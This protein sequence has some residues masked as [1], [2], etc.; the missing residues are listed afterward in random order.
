MIAAP[1]ALVF[2]LSPPTHGAAKK[3]A[4]PEPPPAAVLDPAAWQVAEI[5]GNSHRVAESAGRPVMVSGARQVYLVTTAKHGPD[6]IVRASFRLTNSAARASFKI[7]AGLADPANLRESG[8]YASVGGYQGVVNWS[9]SDPGSKER[10]PVV[11]GVYRPQFAVQRSLGWPESL[12]RGV[13][14]DMVA[15]APVEERWLTFE[16]TLRRQGFEL[17][18]DGIPLTSVS[19]PEL[20]TGGFVRL[21]FSPH[22]ELARAE[23]RKV[24]A[25]DANWVYRPVP[26]AS[27]LN[28]AQI[29][30]RKL[31]RASLPRGT[32]GGVPFEFPEPDSRGNDHA[33][34][35]VSWFRQGNLDGRYSGRGADALAGRWTGAM[36]RDPARL[37][38]RLPM[39]RYR[40]LH[41]IAAADGEPDSVPVITAQF[42]R[43]QAG[44]PK[45]FAARVPAFSAR[46]DDA[47]AIPV[48][49]ADGKP[50]R[51]YH[52]TIPVDAGALAEFDDLDFVEVELTKEVRLYRASPDPM[53]YSTHAAG[54][55]SSVHVFALTAERPAVEMR[56]EAGAYGHIWTAPETPAYTVRLRN[57]QGPAREVRVE[58]TT[59]SFDGRGRTSQKKAVQ[60]PATGDQEVAVRFPLKLKAFGHHDVAVKIVDGGQTRVEPRGLAYLQPDTRERRDWDFGRG[61]LFGFWNW[62]GGHVTPSAEKQLLVMAKAGIES[63]PG[64]YED[65]VRRHGEET[66]K[67]MEQYGIFTLKFAGAG[68]HYITANF[69]K[70]LKSDG[71]EKARAEFI[72]KLKERQSLPGP[73]SRPTFISWYPE[74]SI[75]PLT[76]GIFP[77]YI[78][79]PPYEFTAY[80]QERYH[81]FLNGFLEGAK[82]VRQEFP[83]VRNLM[84]HGDPGFIVHFLRRNPELVKL[85]D[86]VTVD[87][88][89][90]ERLPEQQF[91]QV[92]VHRL[93]MARK[94][95]ADAGLKNPLLP[96]YEGPC[97][98]SGPGALS[99]REQSDLTIRN[100]LILLAYGIDIQNGGF[101]GFDT[102]SY[103]GEQHY[104]F[105]VLNRIALETPKPAYAALAT[106][107]RHLNRKNFHKWVPT[108]SH[109]VYA[110]QFKHYRTGE[111]VHVL[112][113]L[114]G[115]RPVSLQ[116]PANAKVEVFDT[117]DNALKLQLAPGRATFTV[118]TS[119]CFVRGLAGD[120]VIALGAPDHSDAQPAPDAV[121][122]ANFGGDGWKFISQRESGYEESHT[123]YMYRFPAPM[124]ARATAAPAKQG[125]RALA[126]QFPNPEKERVFVPHYSVLTPRQPVPIPG[127]ASHLGVWV[128]GASDWGRIVYFLRDARGEQ[129]INVGVRDAWNCDDLHCWTS[130]NFDGWRYLR[131]ELPNN[132]PY[133]QFR[134]A[135]SAW[136]GPYSGGDGNIDLPLTLEKVVIER[137]THVMY[138]NDPRPAN[139]ADVLLGDLHAE[140]ERPE[141]RAPE[142]VRL[143]AIR[144]PV[145]AEVRGLENPIAQLNREGALPAIQIER[146]TLPPQE[147]DG[148]RCSVHFPVVAGAR[149]YDVWASPYPDGR[150]ALKLGKAWT[151]PGKEIRGLRPNQDF[152][153]FV[154][155]T[156]AEGKTS[157]PSPPHPINL[158]DFFAMK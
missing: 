87:I 97:V 6:T 4:P 96:M 40:A 91:H 26:L 17:S 48:K 117:M 45:S 2:L 61:P 114:R 111:L 83:H 151:E 86:G 134:E 68:D 12:R 20:K 101:P 41:L 133:D 64:S 37:A 93:Y 150:G 1:A 108:G 146:I 136:W 145:P 102:A 21:E 16:L 42:Y 106:L 113:T 23:A 143:A 88:P 18:L 63:T 105:G 46:S 95:M 147:A 99:N 158:K 112:W 19:H 104:G 121:K 94:E 3:A 144:M 140:Y 92:S 148:T 120:A 110:L 58:L 115:S 67:I 100:S 123:P 129:W 60:L 51:L 43:P 5:R 85:L 119:P 33:D 82:I 25:A 55:P 52:V 28:T 22:V 9:A 109:T 79:E 74:P 124:T 135:G 56:L 35:G 89:C 39:A 126:V 156:D 14:A 76:H 34:L 118:D 65:Y 72:A 81:Y 107:T 49:T 31:N 154:T 32:I 132:S 149:S 153:L 30:G 15:S 73:N 8:V 116:L 62:G 54:L 128:K 127:R 11:R 36:M 130:F 50:A 75:G 10:L 53:Y 84:P 137:R 38:L 27:I 77:E 59:T 152:H 66:R 138:V 70:T 131:M 155:Y 125:G 7:T 157:R 141:N 139:R 29:D 71:L 69:A 47:S 103:W 142:A 80:E 57:R 122:L 98:P 90:F 24:A 44:F 13:E 78:G